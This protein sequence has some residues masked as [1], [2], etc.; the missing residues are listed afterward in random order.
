M[1]IYGEK[2]E[3]NI[4]C[5]ILNKQIFESSKQDLI[6]KIANY[7]DRYVG[8]FRPTKPKAKILQNLLQSNEIRFGDALEILFERYF[9]QL[10]F[11]NLEKRIGNGREYFELDQIFKNKNFIYFIEQK[12]R[13]DHDSTKK[14]GQINNFEKKINALLKIYKESE[15]KCYTYF[16]DPGLTKNKRFYTQELEKIYMDYNV[17]TK[18]C[19]GKELWD[20]IGHSEVWT[21][22]LHFLE[23]W[24]KEI[25]DMP[26]I[27]FDD[28]AQNTF[29]EIKD[30]DASLF[31]KMFNNK[32]VCKEILPILFPENKVL[33]L[34]YKYFQEKSVERSIYQTLTNRIK[35]IIV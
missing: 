19:Y 3:Y 4:F 21:E 30:I 6:E 2:M 33:K 8:L 29:E 1:N 12:V 16:I 27:N 25:P 31:R 5:N 11:T 26:S 24:K 13:D 35:E 23:C 28:D 34:L 7:P 10:G 9:E 17:F 15:L 22:L 18:L 14:R 32:E 20:E